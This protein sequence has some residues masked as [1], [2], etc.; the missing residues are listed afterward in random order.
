MIRPLLIYDGD[1]GFCGYWVRYWRKLT[2]DAVDYRPFQEAAADYPDIA[3]PEFQKAVQYIGPDGKRAA[4]A[5]EASF[6]TL[7]HAPGKSVW[8]KLYRRL[9]G[10][11]PAAE[12]AYA[13]IAAHRSAFYSISV[14][15]WG[16]DYEPPRQEVT[17]WI[18]LR[19]LGLIFLAAFVSFGV[20]ALGLIGSRGL[21]PLHEFTT[22]IRA[23][24]GFTPWRFIPMLFWLDD[25]DTAIQAVC[26]TGAAASLL[27]ALGILP[28]LSLLVCYALYMSVMYAG[29]QFLSFQWDMLLVETGFLGLIL[30]CARGPGVWL[31]RLL[32]F[33]FILESGLVKID[34]GDEAWRDFTALDYHFETQPL[35]TPLAWY[36]AHLPHGALAFGTGAT[37]FIELALPLLILLPRRLRFVGGTGFL[38]LQT[39]I[40]LTGNYCFFNLNSPL[41]C[42]MLFDDQAIKN[43]LPKRVSAFIEKRRCPGAAPPGIVSWTAATLAAWLT[44]MAYVPFDQRFIGAPM[45]DSLVETSDLLR[46]FGLSAIY[47]PF[48]VMTRARPEIIIEGSDDGAE[49]KEYGFRYKPCDV[50]RGTAWIIPHQPRLD[51][52]LWFAA[53]DSPQNNPWFARLM[54]RL[55]EG[56]PQALALMGKNPFPDHPPAYVRALL[57]DYHFA[58]AEERAHGIYWDRTKQDVWFPPA[59]LNGSAP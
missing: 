21:L 56:E 20:Q 47:G 24:T 41:L 8:L 27:L 9:P 32:I 50:T 51:W 17:S 23:R 33:R 18:F 57:Y 42:L 38:L 25:S 31:L 3:I 49:W 46:P 28:R 59:H 22:I 13:F 12:A 14:F 1:C 2:G 39:V 29:Q 52:Q 26:W 10:F 58:S 36:A 48:A 40:L 6:L 35:P 7:S 19:L 4:R 53:M 43:I 15:L 16:R 37:L 34:S 45:P 5:A 44:L 11:A 30:V 54:E 55:L